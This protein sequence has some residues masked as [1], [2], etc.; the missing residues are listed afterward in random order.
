MLD[1][2]FQ[3]QR[4]LQQ[5][6]QIVEGGK[7]E[8]PLEGVDGGPGVGVEVVDLKEL[9]DP[10]QPPTQDEAKKVME[11]LTQVLC[12]LFG[13]SGRALIW[14]EVKR[15]GRPFRLYNGCSCN[16]TGDSP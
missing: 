5:L 16:D 4:N 10:S 3:N 11:H 2:S 14:G 15:E 6:A 13:G 7:A 12:P 9:F 8:L 1:S